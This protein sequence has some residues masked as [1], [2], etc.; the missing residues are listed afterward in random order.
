MCA[1]PELLLSVTGPPSCTVQVIEVETSA[2]NSYAV[3]CGSMHG[4]AQDMT[5]GVYPGLVFGAQGSFGTHGV[6]M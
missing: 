3:A 1:N 6:L 2:S 5:H 4:I